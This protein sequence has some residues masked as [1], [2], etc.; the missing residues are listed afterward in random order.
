MNEDNLEQDTEFY[1]L[2]IWDMFPHDHPWL[3]NEPELMDKKGKDMEKFLERV[4]VLPYNRKKDKDGKAEA[5]CLFDNIHGY[6]FVYDSANKQTF[7]GMMCM[8]NTI[9]ELERANKKG[10]GKPKKDEIPDFFP[11]MI[12]IGNKKDLKKNLS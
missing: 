4:I 9:I 7:D 3:D 10:G 11:K 1:D 8:Y 12:V 6:M 2:E 5:P